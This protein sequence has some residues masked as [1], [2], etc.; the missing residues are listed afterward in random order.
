MHLSA[1]AG[2]AASLLCVAATALGA[3]DTNWFAFNPQPDAFAESPMD[4]RFLNEAR[5]A[6]PR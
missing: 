3:E 1:Q 6:G 2:L 4:L 5:R